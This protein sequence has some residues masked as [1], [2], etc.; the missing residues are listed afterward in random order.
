VVKARL[1]VTPERGFAFIAFIVE[2]DYI[3]NLKTQNPGAL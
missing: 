2:E 1:C 3:G